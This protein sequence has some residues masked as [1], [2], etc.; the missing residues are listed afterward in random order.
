MLT[1][2]AL[3]HTRRPR[4]VCSFCGRERSAC[5]VCCRLLLFR[6]TSF[7]CCSAPRAP[8]WTRFFALH[9]LLPSVLE[10]HVKTACTSRVLR[11]RTVCLRGVLSSFVQ[12]DYFR[13]LLGSPCTFLDALFFALHRLL[14]SM[15]ES[16]AK[17]ACSSLVLP[18]QPLNSRLPAARLLLAGRT[19][20]TPSVARQL[21][22]CLPAACQLLTSL[23]THCLQAS[24]V[25]PAIYAQAH[26]YA[27]SSSSGA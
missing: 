5:A 15:F 27:P 16:H 8:F 3:K 2:R 6:A 11:P 13:L 12:S 1:S 25:C 24:H 23:Q 14:P 19:Q 21:A 22:N 20:A 7:G 26:V 9:R 10:S 4:V 18:R 17:T